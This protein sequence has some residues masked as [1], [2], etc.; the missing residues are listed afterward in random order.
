MRQGIPD[1][2]A[3]GYG[4]LAAWADL[5]DRINVFPVA[6]GD[7]GANLRVSLA[8]LR[9]AAADPTLLPQRLGRCAIGNSGN[10]A[11]AFFRELCQ[12][13]AV[14]EL[15]ARAARGR[16]AA[17]QAVAAPRAGT[18]LSVFDAL[19]DGLAALPVIGPAEAG[20]LCRG[21]R[22]AVLDGV[23]QVPELRGAG[24]V[25][26][27][28]LGMYVFFDGVLR[29]L[30]D[31]AGASA[32]VVELFAGWLQ[33]HD[34][35]AVAAPSDFCVDL[36]L[37]S[38]EADRAGLRR[39]IAG[40]GDSVVVGELDGAELKVHVHTP[41]P[42]A[43][44]SR[45]GDLGEITHWSDE[46]IEHTAAAAR[47]QGLRGPL[48]IMTDAAASLPRELARQAGL[49]L[50]D[51]YIVA[52]GESRPESLY[53]P[54]E[55]YSLLRHGKKITTAQASN[56]ERFQHYDSVCRQFGPTLYLATGSAYTGNHAA[57][58][59]WK[60]A[61]DPADLLQ[62]EDSGAASGRL[63]LMALLGARCAGAAD[64]AAAVLACV[65]RLKH[66]C[67]EFVFIDQLRYLV[68]G[69]R[70]SRSRGMFA[71]LLHLKPVISPAPAGV[72]KLGVV[73][74]REGQVDFALARLSERFV[75]AD[76]PTLL[77]QYS[78]NQDW[79]ESVVVARLRQLYP[80]AEILCLPLSLTSGVHMGPG[81]WALACCAAPDMTV[82]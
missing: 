39:R 53:C 70:V 18:M 47:D 67:E 57:A 59:A 23:R 32:S 15:A 21:M 12:A 50:L 13:G 27:G 14:A 4:C 1:S 19:A 5:L 40:L 36:R 63:A 56:F 37:R 26:A 31:A 72:R 41:D 6:D 75:P 69:G 62:V 79:V 38:V 82:P 10:I 76:A 74:S 49:T 66:A 55:I 33:R 16:E 43:L 25:D 60:A 45:L 73:R 17:W 42:A 9:D 71:D 52:E 7:T 3:A 51:S 77:I 11:A 68:A 28:A 24:V 35:A 78:D 20:V 54:A 65:R 80:A 34:D 81:T 8:P 44:R 46:R 48:H 61:Q 64:S 30:T 22:Q 29:A 2:L 58:L